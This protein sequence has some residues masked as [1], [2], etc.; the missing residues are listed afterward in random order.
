MARMIGPRRL[1]GRA[2]TGALLSQGKVRRRTGKGTFVD[3]NVGPVYAAIAKGVAAAADRMLT[4]A[5]ANAPDDP[6]TPTSRVR[7]SGI[8]GVYA[9]GSILDTG[10][11]G[12]WRKPRTYKPTKNGVDSVISFNS[13]L[14]HLHELG[15]VHMPARP[16][17]GPA[18]V[19]VADEVPG[20]LKANFPKDGP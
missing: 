18:R 19:S 14:H 15:T 16:Y 4:E 12:K 20:I 8:W 7:T 11:P 2:L 17:L 10:G 6:A 1:G 9:F 5:T 3:V 13:P